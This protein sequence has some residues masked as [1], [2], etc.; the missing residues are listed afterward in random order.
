M[1][2][3][4]KKI[5]GA[6]LTSTNVTTLYTAPAGTSGLI[7]SITVTNVTESPAGAASTIKI[8]QDGSSDSNVIL[9]KSTLS[10]QELAVFNGVI[11]IEATGTIKA[12]ASAGN[13]IAITGW[14]VEIS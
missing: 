3:T 14:G 1:T 4:P 12:Q 10:E 8:W 13:V 6:L 2:D 11:V 7:K 9:P 5:F